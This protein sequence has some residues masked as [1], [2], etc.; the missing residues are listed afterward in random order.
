MN[1]SDNYY[2]VARG[3]NRIIMEFKYGTVIWRRKKLSWI[4]RIIMEFK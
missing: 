3:I 1:K 4:N 2:L